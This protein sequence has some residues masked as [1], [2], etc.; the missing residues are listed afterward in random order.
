VPAIKGEF[1]QRIGHLV[2]GGEESIYISAGR[3]SASPE[4]RS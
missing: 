4:S 2:K 3:L 1:R